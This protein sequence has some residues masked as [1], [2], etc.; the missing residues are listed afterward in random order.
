MYI[1]IFHKFSGLEKEESLL[2][3]LEKSLNFTKPCKYEPCSV[4]M[5]CV[6]KGTTVHDVQLSR[7]LEAKLLVGILYLSPHIM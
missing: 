5:W 7:G 2:E 1:S 3:V 6:I 4:I